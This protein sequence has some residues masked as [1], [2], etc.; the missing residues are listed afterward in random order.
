M[1][2]NF[3]SLT[4]EMILKYSDLAGAKTHNIFDC[5]T[6]SKRLLKQSLSTMLGHKRRNFLTKGLRG[7]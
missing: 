5:G 3:L 4:G 2:A 1:H 6:A 7:H